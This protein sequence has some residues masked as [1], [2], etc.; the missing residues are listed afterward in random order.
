MSAGASNAAMTRHRLLIRLVEQAL[1]E[2]PG[3]RARWLHA[4]CPAALKA[5]A[6]SLLSA[7]ERVPDDEP[8]DLL[9]LFA[10]AA[11]QGTE[12]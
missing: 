9:A 7:A 2:A 10:R 3:T 8:V 11:L 1:A 5:E 12:S 6:V 4:H